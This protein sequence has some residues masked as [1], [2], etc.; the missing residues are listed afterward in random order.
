MGSGLVATHTISEFIG[1]ANR[2]G[3][4]STGFEA[5]CSEQGPR[6]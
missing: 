3:I 4:A 2:N 6:C 1:P 5:G